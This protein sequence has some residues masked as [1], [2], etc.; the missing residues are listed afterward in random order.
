MADQTTS[1]IHRQDIKWK[2]NLGQTQLNFIQWQTTKLVPF[3]IKYQTEE[4]IRLDTI[5]FH[6]MADQTKLVP[7]VIRI[8]NGRRIQVRHNQISSDGRLQSQYHSS[9]GKNRKNEEFRLDTI[10]F[11]LMADYKVST[12]RHQKRIKRLK[13]LG[14]TQSNFI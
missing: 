10:E 11:Y 14:Q 9:L 12:I 1:T 5:K 8:S 13:N 7:F 3:V 4:E 6:P 2:K